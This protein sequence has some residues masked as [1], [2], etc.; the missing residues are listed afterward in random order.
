MANEYYTHAGAPAQSSSGSSATIRSEFDMIV[1][2]FGKLPSLA[3]NANKLV[4]VNSLSNAL[5]IIPASNFAAS[6]SNN[7]ITSLGALITV[8][9]VVT[10]AI[11]NSVANKA[12]AG[13]N[14]DITSLGA[15]N[16]VPTVVTSAINTAVS[17]ASSIVYAAKGANNDITQLNALTTVPTVITSAINASSSSG[18]YAAKGVNSDITSL[19]VLNAI[20]NGI[21]VNT[22][23]SNTSISIND[24]GGNG[25]NLRLIGNGA[26]TPN[27]SI[28]AAGGLFQIINH[29]YN[30]ALMTVEDNGNLTVPGSINS[31]SQGTMLS[32]GQNG[33]G[34][35]GLVEVGRYFDFHGGNA[36]ATDFDVRFDAT[37]SGTTGAGNLSIQAGG[38]FLNGNNINPIGVNQSWQDKTASRG[39]GVFT[40]TTGRPIFISILVSNINSGSAVLYVNS[41]ALANC[42]IIIQTMLQAL[43]P[44]GNTYQLALSSASLTSWRELV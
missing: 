39:L 27:K 16:T 21:N 9:T 17:S 19:N 34:P 43:V 8:P 4:V 5:T 40:N 26:T 6:G 36:A 37:G 44:N 2:G 24:A 13:S 32:S 42:T 3:G 20:N 38:L 29:A 22:S 7:D 14:N 15:L 11:S 23:N 31:S 33:F 12:N 30:A 18:V 25:A 10:T 41:V 1:S 35:G 28:R